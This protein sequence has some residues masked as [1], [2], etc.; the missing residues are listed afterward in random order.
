MIVVGVDGGG[1]RSRVVV[2]DGLGVV[3]GR[4]E[5][6][7]GLLEPAAPAERAGALAALAREALRTAG[8][9]PPADVLCCG[10][11]GA[12]DERMRGAAR[13]V[14]EAAGVARRVLVVTDV[15]AAFQAAFGAAA[16]GILVVAG[17]GS[18]AW[19]RDGAGRVARCGGWGRHVGDEGSGWWLG[20]AAV[21]AV[22]RAHDGRSGPTRLATPVLRAAGLDDADGLP[23][24]VATAGKPA[25]A[26]LAGGV[27]A[28][29]GEGDDTAG[30]L[31]VEAAAALAELVAA[32]ARRLGPWPEPPAVA[33]AG[34]LF[35]GTP[36][37]A[38]PFGR[39]LQRAVDHHLLPADPAR[40]D[41]ARGA[42][43]LAR[44]AR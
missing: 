43:A 4:L 38:A 19:G 29:A 44:A 22:L 11:A 24:W 18:V 28:A 2:E 16:P 13:A 9:G 42:A 26:A 36:S 27:L 41:A 5:G 33:T 3:L 37:L 20:C 6:G 14:L 23:A 40:R 31:V 12:G 10:L 15:E 35:E 32:L 1:T 17:T 39:A 21:R 25:V 7:P 8:A 34:G 30:R